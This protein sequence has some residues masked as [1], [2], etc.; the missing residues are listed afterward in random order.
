MWSRWRWQD[1]VQFQIQSLDSTHPQHSQGRNPRCRKSQG[2]DQE[3]VWHLQARWC[4]K[5][6]AFLQHNKQS[7][8]NQIY[9]AKVLHLFNV[10]SHFVQTKLLLQ[11]FLGKNTCR[12]SSTSSETVAMVRLLLSSQDQVTPFWGWPRPYLTFRGIQS[13]NPFLLSTFSLPCH[14]TCV[15]KDN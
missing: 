11:R 4:C 2:E 6:F 5:G 13:Q 10:I 15:H 12:P 8:A 14:P 1:V 3:K 7:C 9:I